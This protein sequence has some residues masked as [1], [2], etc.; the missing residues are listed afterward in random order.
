MKINQRIYLYLAVALLAAAIIFV[1]FLGDES[2]PQTVGEGFSSVSL[3][4]RSQRL[5]SRSKSRSEGSP[6]NEM[7]DTLTTAFP[8]I[9]TESSLLPDRSDI[10]PE[11]HE[12]EMRASDPELLAF[13]EQ[14]DD[15]EKDLLLQG[16]A[17]R[18]DALRDPNS[19]ISR[20]L[21]QIH[22][23]RENLIRE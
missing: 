13:E 4:K 2:P 17:A 19:E 6:I 11:L 22:N 1:V 9:Q 23:Q 18:K 3:E 16:G 8:Q 12:I 20:L 21:V 10:P 14:L 5:S 7:P 15:I